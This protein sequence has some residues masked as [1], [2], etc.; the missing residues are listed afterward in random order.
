MAQK[1]SLPYIDSV[2]TKQMANVYF[3]I[4][5]QALHSQVIGSLTQP[6]LG[7]SSAS[8]SPACSCLP[9]AAGINNRNQH[10]SVHP[11]SYLECIAYPFYTRT[12]LRGRTAGDLIPTAGLYNQN[13]TDAHVDNYTNTLDVGE[14]CVH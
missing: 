9:L 1:V 4:N 14:L 10:D 12:N 11:I 3:L 5:L 7:A 13:A 8:G 2:K 6:G